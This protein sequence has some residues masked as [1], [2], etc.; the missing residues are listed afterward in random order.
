MDH[1]AV[2][3]STIASIGYDPESRTLEVAFHHGSVYAYSGVPE[4]VYL[5]LRSAASVGKYFHSN[6][7]NAGYDYRQ[8]R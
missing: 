8:V 6:V 7:R 1:T 3:S 2:Q 4:H 5:G